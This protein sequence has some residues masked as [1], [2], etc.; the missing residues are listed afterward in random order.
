MIAAA[1]IGSVATRCELRF[2]C[3]QFLQ[4]TIVERQVDDQGLQLL[5]L[6]AQLPKFAQLAK[7]AQLVR[8]TLAVFSLRVVIRLPGYAY[9]AADLADLLPTLDLPKRANN[10]LLR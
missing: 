7:L 2:F 4:P 3:E 5:I 10:L 6:F 8:G 1:Y 9:S